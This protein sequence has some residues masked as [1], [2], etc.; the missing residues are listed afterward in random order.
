MLSVSSFA[1]RSC[2]FYRSPLALLDC[3]RVALRDLGDEAQNDVEGH[4]AVDEV[5]EELSLRELLLD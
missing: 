1:L 2:F 5:A 3:I 4:H